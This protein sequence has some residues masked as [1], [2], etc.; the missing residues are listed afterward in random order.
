MEAA[1][2]YDGLAKSPARGEQPMTV[3]HPGPLPYGPQYP[4]GAKPPLPQTVQNAFYLMLAGAVLQ[5]TGIIVAMTQVHQL[6]AAFTQGDSNI[7]SSDANAVSGGL[8]ALIVFFGVVETGLWIWMAY[9]NKAGRPWARI[10][11]T[12]LFGFCCLSVVS[13]V[14]SLAFRSSL[15]R[16]NSTTDSSGHT[17]TVSLSGS[18]TAIGTTVG[19][20]MWGI[21]LAAIILL[22]R[23]QSSAYFVPAL[24]YGYGPQ[25]GPPGYPPPPGYPQ[26]PGYPPQGYAA[27]SQPPPGQFPHGYNTQ[28]YAAPP[29]RFTPPPVSD[30]PSAEPSPTQDGFQ[31]PQ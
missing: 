3:G 27:P 22:W 23:R 17:S 8:V 18:T 19:V 26:A 28:G 1:E 31:P 13:S 21:G 5:V 7:S 9:K 10:V 15:N 20:I 14:L 29:D 11:G 12:V 24:A 4:R 16:V 2:A 25:G 6:R 30:P